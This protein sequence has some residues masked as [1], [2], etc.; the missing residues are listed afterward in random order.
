VAIGV[1]AMAG[2]VLLLG[3]T[4]SVQSTQEAMHQTIAQGIAEQL[5]DEVVGCRYMAPGTTPYQIGLGPSGSEL[6]TGT[7][8][9]FND[10]D[11]FH[12]FTAQPP[13]DPWGVPLGQ[14]DGA[15][16]E[17]HP[18][19]QLPEGYFDRWREEIKVYYVDESDLVTPLPQGQTSDYR[20][21]EVRVLY[22]R[23]EGG[24]RELAR[25]RRVVAYVPPL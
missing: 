18:A 12:D 21:V 3:L 16:G 24:T 8:E 13:E 14:D 19:F 17:R 10:V 20:L 5:A 25:V 7:R 11:D 22:E 2:S 1:T 15:G 9:L 6:A 23:P 4:G